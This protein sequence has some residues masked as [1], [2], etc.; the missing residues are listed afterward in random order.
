[1]RPMLIAIEGKY[2]SSL[3]AVP[4]SPYHGQAAQLVEPITGINECCSARLRFLSEELKGFQCPLI[5]S[6]LFLALDCP[7]LL[8][9]HP[10]RLCH[11]LR[12]LLIC[13]P[14]CYVKV[15]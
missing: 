1:M 13:N 2:R 11:P 9:L 10:Q 8:Y 3:P 4:H 7:F 15:M 12:C 6:T 5:P 14:H